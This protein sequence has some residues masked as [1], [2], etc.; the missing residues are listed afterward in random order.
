MVSDW[1]LND[2][3]F[4]KKEGGDWDNGVPL[5]KRDWIFKAIRNNFK[6]LW[7]FVQGV[8]NL[9]NYLNF[10]SNHKKII[11]DGFGI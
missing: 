10:F 4:R 11:F 8:G 2:Q 1:H 7:I 5:K 3:T 6:S 9:M